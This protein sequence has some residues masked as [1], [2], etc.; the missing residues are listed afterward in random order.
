MFQFSIPLPPIS[1]KAPL[2]G[3]H[4]F[5][6]PV[7]RDKTATRFYLR[8]QYQ[9]TPIE[10]YTILKFTFIFKIP[11]SYSK[12]KIELIKQGLLIP[13]RADCTNLQKF[14]EDCLKNIIIDDDRNVAKIFSEKIYGEKEEIIIKVFTLKEFTDAAN[15]R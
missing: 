1:W 12:K 2:K 4:G 13:T 11:K 15:Q 10:E 6:D 7:G 3:K 14:Y 8:E 5:Y 9:H